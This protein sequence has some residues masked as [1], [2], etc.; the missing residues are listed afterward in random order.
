MGPEYLILRVQNL[1]THPAGSASDAWIQVVLGLGEIEYP[2]EFP[3]GHIAPNATE[4]HALVD[5]GGLTW[6]FAEIT[7]VAFADDSGKVCHKAHGLA[8]LERR[9]DGGSEPGYIT[10]G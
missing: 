4:I 10:I 3:L 7:Y 6:I 1:Q 2:F 8:V 5:L 9:D